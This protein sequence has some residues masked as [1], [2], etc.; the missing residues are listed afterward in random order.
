MTRSIKGKL[1]D[2]KPTALGALPLM[3]LRDFAPKTMTALDQY[4]DQRRLMDADRNEMHSRYDAIAQ[5]W[6]KARI[7]S[8]SLTDRA[9]TMAG[10]RK[11]K[12]SGLDALMHDA[13]IMS[14]DPSKE[15]K[16]DADKSQYA[17][18]RARY[19]ALPAKQKKLFE[20]VRDAYSDQIK[21]MEEVIQANIEKSIA[22][23]ARRA[24]R[25]MESEIRQIRD[26]LTGVEQEIAIEK[27]VK[28]FEARIKSAEAGKVS[29]ALVLRQKFEQMRV[30]E[31]YFP[32]KRFGDYFVSLRDKNGDLQSFSMFESAADME[33]AAEQFKKQYPNLDVV[34]GRKSNKEDFREAIDP[35]FVSDIQELITEEV[36]DSALTDAIYQMYLETLPD[37]SMRKSF[38]HRKKVEGYNEDAMRAFAS[39]MFHSS[40]QIARLK[41]K[42]EMDEL[43]ETAEE[44]AHEAKDTVDAMTVA[45]ELR[46]RHEWV[47]NP[48]GSKMAQRITSAAFIY[49]LGVTP[50]AAFVN[51]T[52]TFI[53][54]VP[55]L[56]TRFKNE[57]AA[58][59]ELLKASK[60]F[61]VGKGKIE[62]SLTGN[63]K[64]ALI[65]FERMGLIEKT[66]AHDLAGVGDTGVEYS[67][68][69]QK[70]MSGI[71]FLFH[72]AERYNREVTSIAAYRMAVKSGMSHE[73]AIKEAA[74]LTWTTHFDY[75]SGNRARFMQNDTA[76]VLL[77][78]RQYSVN[79]LSRLAV[80]TRAMFKG[81]SKEVRRE[82]F[83][84][85]AGMYGMFAL[86]AGMMGVPGS[87]ALLML[88]EALDWDDEDP[89]TMEDKIKR[90]VT[91]AL[92]EDVAAAFFNGV[93]GTLS[94][95]DLTNRVGLGHLWFFSPNRELE[96]RDQYV[97]WME[98]A[99][100][101]A[102]SMIANTFSGASM[103][104][105]GHVA[106]GLETMMPKAGKDLMRS[107]RYSKEGVQSL[108]G[109]SVVD[110]LSTWGVIAQA[111]GFTPAHVAEQYDK[112]SAI[113]GAEQRILRERRAILNRY[114]LAVRT[115]DEEMR[116]KL[117][118]RVSE[119][120]RKNPT[121]RITSQTIMQSMIRRE[122]ARGKAEGGVLIDKRLDHLRREANPS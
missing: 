87:Q 102:P 75:S 18:L 3:Y 30:D 111:M 121:V 9:M 25:E 24:K 103:M 54:G 118:S 72:H 14:I 36:G 5:R 41:Y 119:F 68:V 2:I 90:S 61:A 34:V 15:R 86:F 96:G 35:T 105:E 50:A 38:I 43:V 85:M 110:E 19:E 101:A 64:K 91:E 116:A 100:G 28:R 20:D 49:Q 55:V 117:S 60:D 76:K 42:L 16:P 109:Y 29:R 63:E 78:F 70:V 79:M 44:Q 114:A 39:S 82:A 1:A 98:Q 88:L 48:Q 92:G 71:A 89:W 74:D 107:V 33:S 23:A 17:I 99:L 31:P 32:L 45:N 115:G 12:A 7:G 83:R 27:S 62:N 112:N 57:A 81:E 51:T 26:E 97:Y 108:N 37:F 40:H 65:E 4:M 67:A 93:I 47:M 77:V 113:K 58:T 59:K 46:K 80:D 73:A 22:F 11:M 66:Q 56:G 53:L 106:R 6:L 8:G 84:R 94:G 13:T 122:Q 10:L 95:T 21:T 104:A 52:Q 69:R 120:N